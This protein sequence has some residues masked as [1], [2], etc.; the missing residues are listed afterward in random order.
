[1]TTTM[2]RILIVDDNPG[3]IELVRIAFE[4]A[5][6][7]VVIE[8]VPDGIEAMRL[9]SASAKDKN[10]PAMVLLDL[11]MP[12]A[13]GFEVLDFMCVRHLVDQVPVI[14]LSTSRQ[15]EDRR[16]CLALGARAMHSK[17]ESIL[18]LRRLIEDFR[19]YLSQSIVGGPA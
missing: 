13:N 3:D 11:N 4:M 9:L 6:I 7:P 5:G 15:L 8:S 19:V 12:R 2:H 14:I 10:L 16:R 18:D 17:P 1:M